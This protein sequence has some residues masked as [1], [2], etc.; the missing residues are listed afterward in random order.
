MAA[1]SVKSRER[2]KKDI[3]GETAYSTIERPFG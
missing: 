2:K 1:E 3:R